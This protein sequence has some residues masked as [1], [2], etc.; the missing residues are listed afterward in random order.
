MYRIWN[1]ELGQIID[2]DYHKDYSVDMDGDVVSPIAFI[3]EYVDAPVKVVVKNSKLINQDNYIVQLY[4]DRLD[5]K[6]D[7]IC[8]GDVVGIQMKDPKKIYKAIVKYGDCGFYLDP[9]VENEWIEDWS[10]IDD[11]HRMEIIGNI[12]EDNNES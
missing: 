9:I 6:H 10:L 7:Y 1:K 11:N 5:I 12:M 2:D 3:T 4:T 8:E